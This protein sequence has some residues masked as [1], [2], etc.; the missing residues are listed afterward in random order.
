MLLN[1]IENTTNMTELEKL[2]VMTGYITDMEFNNATE[3]T[4][5]FIYDL[6]DEAKSYDLP[7]NVNNAL[8]TIV[9]E[10]ENIDTEYVVEDE[11][12]D[13]MLEA[14]GVVVDYLEEMGA[15]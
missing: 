7:A 4:I 5:E 8:S 15:L 9:S 3:E 13:E 12:I 10:L 2:Y 6:A 1:T 14:N 11:N